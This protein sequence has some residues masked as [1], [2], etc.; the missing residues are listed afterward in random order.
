MK[1][2]HETREVLDGLAELRRRGVKAALATVVRVRGSAY[3]H[4]GAKLL[5][6]EDGS[7][8][9]NVSG[10]CL[11]QDVREVA[12]QVIRTGRAEL[13]NYCSSADEIEAWDL[14]VG[15]EGQ[16][17]VFVEPA[18]EARPRERALLDGREPFAVA[19][20]VGMGDARCGMRL[21]VTRD[22]IDGTLGQAPLDGQAVARAR[23]LLGTGQCGLHEIGGRTVFV[24]VFQP[25]PQLVLF[26]AG[27]DARPLARFASDVGFRV[28]VVDRRPGYLTPERFPTVARLVES[29]ATGLPERLALDEAS[30]AIVMTHNFADDQAYL[31]ALLRAPVSYI[32]MLGP[33][34]RTERILRNLGAEG[35]LDE[36]R[37][38]GPVGLDIGTDGAEQVALSVI[39]EILGLR[40]GRRA[41]SLRERRAPIHAPED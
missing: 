15:C 14:G 36:S 25:P 12:L 38:Y 8:T 27:E 23:G 7:T 6:A 35:P 20:I 30:Y 39:A 32:G 33:R 18:L 29:D 11:E 26:G 17:D 34:Q 21:M 4:E 19:T 28:V 22:R 16:V 40:S 10:G 2:W 24:D 31:R 5:V 1:K 9:G 37:V 3:R 41:S 13:R